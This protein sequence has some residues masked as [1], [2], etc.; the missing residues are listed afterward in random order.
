MKKGEKK[1]SRGSDLDSTKSVLK[2]LSND[3]RRNMIVNLAAK[4]MDVSNISEL[5]ECSQST[6]RRNLKILVDADL[7]DIE[8]RNGKRVYCLGDTISVQKQRGK[9]IL[10]AKIPGGGSVA[11][12]LNWPPQ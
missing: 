10:K 2:L 4:P 1:R 7:L 11:M 9:V 12:K 5:L 8:Q 3:L 6:A